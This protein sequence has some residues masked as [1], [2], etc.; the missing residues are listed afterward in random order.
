MIS[1][2]KVGP[3]QAGFPWSFMT[4]EIWSVSCLANS[5]NLGFPTAG[6]H[7]RSRV[8]VAP[9]ALYH[10][11]FCSRACD[12][13]CSKQ[14]Q[15]WRWWRS[16]WDIFGHTEDSHGFPWIPMDSLTNSPLHPVVK[17]CHNQSESQLGSWPVH[18][19]R[20]SR[21]LETI[22]R[23]WSHLLRW[24]KPPARRRDVQWLKFK[25]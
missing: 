4:Y 19:W 5:W 12:S 17:T 15:G 1:S 20:R 16:F 11:F 25:G 8:Q 18:R 21:G 24:M 13:C 10:I 6:Q 3:G 9:H 14:R 7:H 23:I 22:P 2:V